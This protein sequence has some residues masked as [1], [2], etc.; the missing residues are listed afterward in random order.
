MKRCKCGSLYFY[1]VEEKSCTIFS[2]VDDNGQSQE[3][4]YESDHSYDSQG[5]EC[6]ICHAIFNTWDDIPEAQE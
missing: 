4:V 6:Q 5:Y 3:T 2:T 1:L